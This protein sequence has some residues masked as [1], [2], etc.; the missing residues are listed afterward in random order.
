MTGVGGGGAAMIAFLRLMSRNKVGFAGFLVVIA[1]L[2]LVLV[3]PLFVELDDRTHLD[4][5]YEPPSWRHPLGTD[6]Q[7]KDIWS[8]I[9]HGGREIIYV[10]LL[11]AVIA[12]GIAVGLG[13]TA[14]FAGGRVDGAVLGFADI[15]LTIPQFP[16]LA[17]IAGFVKLNHPATVALILGLLDWPVLLRAVRSQVLSIRERDFVEAARSLGL[18][19]RHIVLREILPNML[20]YLTITFILGMTGAMYAQVGLILLGLVPMATQNWGVMIY[21]AWVRGAIF[22]SDSILFI[23]API[24]AI[25]VFQLAL[26]STARSLEEVFNPRLRTGG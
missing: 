13:S 12:T 16:L 14:A 1:T 10:A 25:A 21:L 22:F 5:I 9:V 4:R 8:Q 3:G 7:G 18:P 17:V 20:S 24:A 2:L 26:V 11:T 6:H 15:V 23:L 19:T